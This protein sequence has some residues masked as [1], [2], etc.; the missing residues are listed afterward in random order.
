M[1]DN[2]RS[3]RHEHGVAGVEQVSRS[4]LRG[5]YEGIDR[6]RRPLAAWSLHFCFFNVKLKVLSL[7][8]LSV[9]GLKVD[10]GHPCLPVCA[11]PDL[12][13]SI[14]RFVVCPSATFF[15]LICHTLRHKH[16]LSLSI[17]LSATP[18]PPLPRREGAHWLSS[19][20]QEE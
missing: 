4:G 15:P 17:Y 11:S 2:Q 9:R 8:K 6:K 13:R 16:T 14:C 20:I 1:W 10:P 3:V 18:P 19:A 5:S 12:L 7:W